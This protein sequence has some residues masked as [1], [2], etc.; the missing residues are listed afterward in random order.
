MSMLERA[1]RAIDPPAWQ[2]DR[3]VKPWGDWKDR[4]AAARIGAR[5]A[6]LAAL[7]PADEALVE[8]V[9]RAIYLAEF[10]YDQP[11]ADQ[12]NENW[13]ACDVEARAAVAALKATAQ[14]ELKP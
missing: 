7:N 14:G 5:A 10:H 4:Q 12:V 3:D 8:I 13:S 6:L 9:A 2:A 1:A 11:T